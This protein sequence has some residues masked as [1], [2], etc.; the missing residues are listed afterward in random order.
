[1]MLVAFGKGFVDL[2]RELLGDKS[3][4][5]KERDLN[6][7]L[8]FSALIFAD[9]AFARGILYGDDVHPSD[10]FLG[11]INNNDAVVAPKVRCF[12]SRSA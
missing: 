3:F 8:G 12:N 11:V 4:T 1:M 7:G 2:F 6:I 10:N 9:V 5:V